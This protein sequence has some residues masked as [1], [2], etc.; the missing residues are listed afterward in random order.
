M[1]TIENFS[2]TNRDKIIGNSLYRICKNETSGK[3][4]IHE[5]YN[6]QH[7]FAGYNAFHNDDLQKVI[8]AFNSISKE[9]V[10]ISLMP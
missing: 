7:T 1:L 3:W 2:P 5:Q 4:Y 6:D 8:D 10:I 9:R